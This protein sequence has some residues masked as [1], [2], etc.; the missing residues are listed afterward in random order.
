M[1]AVGTKRKA[2]TSDGPVA[3]RQK[4]A[5]AKKKRQLNVRIE[6]LLA[7][8]KKFYDTGAEITPLSTTWALLDPAT[9]NTYFCPVQNDGPSNRDGR[10][11]IA[12]A[13]N[14]KG[15]VQFNNVDDSYT[16]GNVRLVFFIDKQS[17]GAQPTASTVIG[18][19]SGVGQILGHPVLEYAK[20]FTILK[21]V[22]ISRGEIGRYVDQPGLALKT[23]VYQ[24]MFEY[25]LDLKNRKFEFTPSGG[26][27]ETIAALV[28]NSLHVV[29]VAD[30][31]S[32][33]YVGIASRVF[34]MG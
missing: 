12:T 19:G 9:K 22:T 6:G 1:P 8:E 27:T 23:T 34:F 21:D 13:W 5:A 33:V 31:G 25:K 24:H 3:K 32:S 10:E 26:T 15:M 4:T 20:R 28:G 29:A 16:A 18:T 30:V 17:N 14:V 11:C 2:S 7:Q